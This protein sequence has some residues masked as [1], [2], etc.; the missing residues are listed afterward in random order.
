MSGDTRIWNKPQWDHYHVQQY[1][2]ISK[3]YLAGEMTT[4]GMHEEKER[5][6]QEFCVYV[7]ARMQMWKRGY[8]KE[9][10]F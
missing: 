5:V 7:R 4:L 8:L 9:L 10:E 1:S 6:Y 3:V 2:T